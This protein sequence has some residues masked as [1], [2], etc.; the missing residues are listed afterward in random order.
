M[1]ENTRKQRKARW[2]RV[3]NNYRRY[4]ECVYGDAYCD[5]VY[6]ATHPWQWVD[7]RFLSQRHKRRYFAVAAQTLLYKAY[8]MAEELADAEARKDW[9]LPED[10]CYFGPAERDPDWGKVYEL[11]TTEEY[12]AQYR[13]FR[14][15]YEEYLKHFLQKPVVLRPTIEVRLEYGPVAVGIWAK[16]NK[17]YL[18][19]AALPEFAQQFRDLGEPLRQGIV[20]QGEEVTV[21]PAEIYEGA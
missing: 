14:T 3:K 20:W 7:F 17:P 19:P 6:D 2:I 4:P 21:V 1:R 13:H 8:G 10:G 9:P 18:N 5:H 11:R 12:D 15:A 16:L